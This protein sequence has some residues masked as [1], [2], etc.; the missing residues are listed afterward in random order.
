MLTQPDAGRGADHS[1][2]ICL[3]SIIARKIRD[4][5]AFLSQ[6]Y[7]PGDEIFLFG[8]S[9]GAYT[10]R[11]VAGLIVRCILFPLIRNMG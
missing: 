1:R 9:R 5:Y 7:T 4:A 3:G 2:S 10:A 8:F 6:N 11:K